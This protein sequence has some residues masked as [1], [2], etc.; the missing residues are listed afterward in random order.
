MTADDDDDVGA[1]S[2]PGAAT[3]A[4]AETAALSTVLDVRP[5]AG[6]SPCRRR[7]PSPMSAV[8]LQATTMTVTV[9][10][11]DV[12]EMHRMDECDD[13]CDDVCPIASV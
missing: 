8:S 13:V 7:G 5:P 1:T 3:T 11:H 4:G 6:S 2:R 10:N 12:I 9:D